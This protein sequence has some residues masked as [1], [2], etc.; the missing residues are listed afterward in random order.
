MFRARRRS[1]SHN[2]FASLEK[3]PKYN[4]ALMAVCDVTHYI[5]LHPQTVNL[6]MDN[7]IAPAT[8]LNTVQ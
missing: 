2:N 6:L 8:W 3:Q 5:K 7:I 4:S 1:I